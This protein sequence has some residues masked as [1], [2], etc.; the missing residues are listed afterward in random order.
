MMICVNPEEGSLLVSLLK[1]QI[2][3]DEVD[4]WLK[5]KYAP[6]VKKIEKEM[7]EVNDD[8]EIW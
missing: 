6:I 7:L 1:F 5:Q 3:S 2:D 8:G 4:V